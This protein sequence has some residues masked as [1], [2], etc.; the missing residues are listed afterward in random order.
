MT[1][2]KLYI[3]FY[4]ISIKRSFNKYCIKMKNVFREI[5]QATHK[6]DNVVIVRSNYNGSYN[7][8]G[9]PVHTHIWKQYSWYKGATSGVGDTSIEVRIPIGHYFTIIRKPEL[10]NKGLPTNEEYPE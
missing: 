9:W 2:R 5:S 6:L 7:R 8:L 4:L 10:N 3:I 1:S